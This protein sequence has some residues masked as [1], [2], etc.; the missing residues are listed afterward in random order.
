MGLKSQACDHE[1]K[2]A[3]AMPQVLDV[4]NKDIKVPSDDIH[5]NNASWKP[6]WSFEE[7]KESWKLN[8]KSTCRA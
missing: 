2:A 1:S 3:T 5:E 6:P 7:P 8:L 4:L